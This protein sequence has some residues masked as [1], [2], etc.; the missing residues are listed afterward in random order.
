MRVTLGF[1]SEPL[2]LDHRDTARH[3]A[4][5]AER[6]AALG[7]DTPRLLKAMWQASGFFLCPGRRAGRGGG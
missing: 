2:A 3:K 6:M 1:T 5:L 7:G 4:V